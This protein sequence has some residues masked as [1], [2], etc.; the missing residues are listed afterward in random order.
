MNDSNTP[1]SSSRPFP[2]AKI[3]AA[4]VACLDYAAESTMPPNKSTAMFLR[5]LLHD[6]AWTP[7]E[8]EA[9]TLYVAKIVRG[10][11]ARGS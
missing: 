4:I 5:Q 3:D 2:P 8:V 6:P 10:L 7:D 11:A 9:V 1:E